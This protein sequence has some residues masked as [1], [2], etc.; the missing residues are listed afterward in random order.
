MT[1]T[2]LDRIDSICR[3][4]EQQK[5]HIGVL[6]EDIDGDD[7]LD[8]IHPGGAYQHLQHAIALLNDLYWD[9]ERKEKEADQ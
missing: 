9:L 8:S 4:I 3:I 1:S 7:R 6:D 5:N 2:L